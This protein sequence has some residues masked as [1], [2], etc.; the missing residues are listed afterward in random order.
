M[1]TFRLASRLWMVFAV[2]A[3]V[4]PALSRE[5]VLAQEIH[6]GDLVAGGDGSGNAPPGNTGIDPARGQFT[7]TFF[8]GVVLDTDGVNPSPVPGSQYLDSVFFLSGGAPFCPPL[9]CLPMYR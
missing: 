3:L 6:L 8:D 9:G 5:G 1:L 2:L 7:S 4:F